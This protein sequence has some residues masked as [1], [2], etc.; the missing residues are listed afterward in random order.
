MAFTN[1]C[2]VRYFLTATVTLTQDQDHHHCKG[3]RNVVMPYVYIAVTSLSWKSYFMCELRH[4]LYMI[5]GLVYLTEPIYSEEFL[6]CYH[7]V[8]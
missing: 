3:H 2:T 7:T 1:C 4:I 6:F 5:S 8:M